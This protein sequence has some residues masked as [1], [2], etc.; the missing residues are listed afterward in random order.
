MLA[1]TLR[2]PRSRRV[3]DHD[4]TML[5]DRLDER[6]DDR[7]VEH[8]GRNGA[9]RNRP[10]QT[11]GIDADSVVQARDDLVER[12]SKVRAVGSAVVLT[13]HLL[14]Q[15]Q[16]HEFP[17]RQWRKRQAIRGFGAVITVAL[18]VKLD[19]RTQ[20]VAEVIEIASNRPG[21][22]LQF[23]RERLCDRPGPAAQRFVKGHDPSEHGS[24]RRMHRRG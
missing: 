9:E 23:T 13:E 5:K 19:R 3:V 17:L 1:A 6:L 15:E 24:S 11:L 12:A 10:A 4:A 7:D 14:G 22:D 18:R 2:V 21:V 20:A 16:R 8:R